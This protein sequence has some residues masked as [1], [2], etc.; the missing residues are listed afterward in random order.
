[1]QPCG[2]SSTSIEHSSQDCRSHGAKVLRV[3]SG[4]P[5]TMQ[6]IYLVRHG[7]DKVLK[8]TLYLVLGSTRQT[9]LVPVTCSTVE[10]PSLRSAKARRSPC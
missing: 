7:S 4:S 9:V 3:R 5:T 10:D 6:V 1:M 8:R 2:D